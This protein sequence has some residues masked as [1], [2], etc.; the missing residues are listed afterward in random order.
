VHLPLDLRGAAGSCRGSDLQHDPEL[1]TT[2][3]T[4]IPSVSLRS[5]SPR[6][7]ALLVPI[8]AMSWLVVRPLGDNSFLWHV[9][10]GTVQIDLGRVLTTDPFSFTRGGE[11]WRTQSW[12]AEL[13]YGWLE[14]ATGDLSWVPLMVYAVALAMMTLIAIAVYDVIREPVRTA[15]VLVVVAF[16]STPF[17]VPRPVILSYTLIAATVVILRRPERLAWA[18][19][20][21]IWVWA[22]LHAS[23]TLGL[24]LVALEAFRIKSWRL[25]GIGVVAGVTT[26]FTAHGLG[27]WEFLLKFFESRDALRFITE[28]A[29]PNFTRMFLAPF[30]L[31]IAGL[32][33]GAVRGR[34]HPRDLV[35]IVPFLWLG[36]TQQRSILPAV[37]VLAPFAARA[38]IPKRT[39]A[40]NRGGSPVANAALLGALVI[41]AVV[42]FSRNVSLRTN[43][44]PPPEARQAL[45]PGRAFHGASAGGLL[46]YADWPERE[47]Y[48]DDRAELYGVEGFQEF[49]DATKGVGYE[50]VF[51]EYGLD[52]ALVKTDWKLVEFLQEDGWDL[53]Y[54]D[55]HWAVYAR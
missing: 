3:D 24:A 23:Y 42:P 35:V 49:V 8:A 11:E 53:R 55:E 51:A 25:V 5:L 52:Q 1:N 48:V 28:W 33:A 46:I 18:L 10:A 32:V 39:P 31:L 13:G 47:V 12:L 54:E 14:R 2:T 36:L 17:M 22:G 15:G 41:L 30:L 34:I 43:I 26:A 19:V 7:L 21:M 16:I 37:I 20:P 44:L 9:R 50:E 6:Q 38:L 29:L 40:P 4:R 45:E 27:S